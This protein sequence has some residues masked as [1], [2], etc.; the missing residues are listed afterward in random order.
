MGRRGARSL[1]A[2]LSDYNP[3]VGFNHIVDTPAQTSDNHLDGL[4]NGMNRDETLA[5][6]IPDP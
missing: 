1:K 3:V 4:W 6:A 5:A 2:L